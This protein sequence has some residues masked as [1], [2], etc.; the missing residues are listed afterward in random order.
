MTELILKPPQE[1]MVDWLMSVKRG[2]LWAGMGIGKTSASLVVLDWLKILGEL[3][4]RH[5]ALIVGPMRVARDTWPDEVR[6][7][8]QFR[9]LSITP[10][11]GTPAERVELLRRPSHLF[12]VSYELAPW[13]VEQWVERWPYRIVIADE[14]DRLKGFR[15]KSKH[16]T[17][18]E[19]EKS[20]RSGKRAHQLARIAHNGT[21]RW[22]N[23]TGTPAPAGLKD[24]WGQTW[25][26]DRGLRLGRTFGAF[27]QRWFRKK[28]NSDY[29]MEPMPHSDAEIHG[30]LKDIYLTV[31]PKDYF[32]LKDPI[33]TRV[34]VT[35]PP[36]ARK[37]YQK[38]RDEMY[39]ALEELVQREGINIVNAGVLMQKCLQIANGAVYVDKVTREWAHVHDAKLEA[40][41]SIVHEAGG[42]PIMVAYNF[43]SDR[44]RILKAFPAAVDISTTEGLAAFKSGKRTIGVAHPKSMGHGIDGLQ[45]VTNILVF[46]GHDPKTGERMQFIERAGPMR[47]LQAKLDRPVWVYDIVAKDTEDENVMRIHHENKSVQDVLLDAMNRRRQ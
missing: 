24:L 6:K 45:Y 32:D 38:A 28:W 9:D 40:L 7:W 17:K 30:L 46:F 26:L 12:T 13:L 44:D 25:Y 29:G 14:S 1:P 18:L 22:I 27:Q 5:P 3:D 35:L 37:L 10:L 21:D 19:S 20:G 42:A 15:E 4:V 47:Q 31:D 41:D 36:P 43:R 23:L 11:V 16:G 34:S 33:Y 8:D 2:G 39:I